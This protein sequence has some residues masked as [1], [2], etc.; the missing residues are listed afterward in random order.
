MEALARIEDEQRDLLARAVRSRV[1]PPEMGQIFM[2]PNR[3]RRLTVVGGQGRSYQIRQHQAGRGSNK[4]N[5][6]PPGQPISK[7]NPRRRASKNARKR[8]DGKDKPPDPCAQGASA[9]NK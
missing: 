3:D 5:N 4:R 7:D 9:S 6:P 2:E 8:C 1:G